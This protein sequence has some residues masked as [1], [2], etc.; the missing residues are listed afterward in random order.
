MEARHYPT[1]AYA[2]LVETARA[3]DPLWYMDAVIY[4]VH[5]KAFYDSN[6]GAKRTVVYAA[7]KFDETG[8]LR[9]IDDAFSKWKEGPEID[10]SGPSAVK[11][12]EV[13]IID[14]PGAPQTTF[15]ASW[16]VLICCSSCFLSP[17]STKVISS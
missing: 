5:V 13:A 4:Q 14:R 6:Y 11:T 2:P 7:G 8:V 3:D 15:S 17:T 1:G 9:A 16:C 12:N 10:Y